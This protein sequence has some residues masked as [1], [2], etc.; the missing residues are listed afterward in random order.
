M[1]GRLRKLVLAEG[2]RLKSVVR[3]PAAIG[4]MP[5]ANATCGVAAQPGSRNSCIAGHVELGEGAMLIGCYVHQGA[6]VKLGPGTV[7]YACVFYGKVE[8]GRDCTFLGSCVGERHTGG[9]LQCGD[10]CVVAS[11]GI[12]RNQV[13]T[14]RGYSLDYKNDGTCVRVGNG[15]VIMGS[16]LKQLAPDMAVGSGMVLYNVCFEIG[17][18]DKTHVSIGDR[19]T[20]T[21]GYG[22]FS[23]VAISEI[24]ERKDGG[25]HTFD[26]LLAIRDSMNIHDRFVQLLSHCNDIRIGDDVMLE[27]SMLIHAQKDLVIGDGCVVQPCLAGKSSL[28]FIGRE[29]SLGKQSMITVA[30]D[31]QEQRQYTDGVTVKGTYGDIRTGYKSKLCV[32]ANAANG[33]NGLELGDNETGYL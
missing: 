17:F 12:Y 19:F 29:V 18:N 9:G 31:A 1:P 5:D 10:N 2:E 11:S 15:C 26:S 4:W 20:I 32:T 30:T 21:P 28:T 3:E 23:K 24:P 33:Y 6:E 13:Y 8:T 14:R 7:A 22:N 25:E 16:S 27:T